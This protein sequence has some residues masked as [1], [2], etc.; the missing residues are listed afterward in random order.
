MGVEEL[1]R[2]IREEVK[3][4]IPATVEITD[5]EFEAAVLVI[6]TKHPER[7]AE[8]EDLVRRLAKK[9]RKRVVVRPDP[10]VLA[11][12][13][14]AD[15]TIRDLVPA[16]AEITE[17]YF[18][19]DIGEVIIEA[20][21]P[22]LVIGRHG[23]TL[24]DIKKAIG[25]APKVIR[26]PPIPSKNVKEIRQFLRT[27]AEERKE[28][29]HRV[30]RRIYRGGVKEDQWVRWTSLGGYREVGRSC[31]LLQTQDTKILIDCGVNFSNDDKA[32]PYLHLSEVW[33]LTQID[34]VILTHAH[35]DHCGLIPLLFKYGYDGPVY[36][37]P[38]TRDLA[39]LLCMD[40]I[41]IAAA[42]GKKPPY[43]SD[44]IRDFVKHS[45]T[46]EYGDTTDIAPDVKLTFSNSGHIL[47]AAV[48]H[49]HIGDGFYNVCCT[50]DMKYER[51]WLFN[52]TNNKFPRLETLIIEATYGGRNDFQ[53]TRQQAQDQM[54]EIC[55]RVL[56]R[57]GKLVVPCFAVGRSQEIMLVMEELIRNGDVP[58][59]PVYL[60]GMI[61]EATAIHTAY[62]EY[63]NN[64]LRNEIFHEGSNPLLSDIF[65]RVDSQEMRRKV[66]DSDEPCVVLA[67][68]GMMSGGPVMEY[69]R[70][71]AQDRR[72]ALVFVGFQAG[73]TLGRRI[74]QGWR[75]I[76]MAA[77]GG[78]SGVVKVELDV[79][80]VDGFSGHSDRRQLMN[81]INNI[82]PKP[83]HVIT[84][85]GE[86]SK[87]IDFATSI[88]KKYH[89]RTEAPMNLET[90]R[91]K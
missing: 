86:E 49:F 27:V 53:P 32:T 18:E 17:L 22:G 57:G 82:T 73:G 70:H 87:C 34:A 84:M 58:R 13:E 26:T 25:W 28:I 65:V 7:F 37:T 80:T 19:P 60:D 16:E 61:W 10:S 38:P 44:H 47:G 72:N 31:H 12:I 43:E 4:E 42:E 29:L 62:P 2:E 14:K 40:Y 3:K 45:V 23:T 78:R 50:S 81:Y 15:K 9:L 88:H 83:D 8:D 68:S 76:P 6:Y 21:K 39:V 24:N 90:I 54:K 5:I 1:L 66:L 91:L 48:S 75:E 85:H 56:P 77:G 71:W 36:L 64:E 11:N 52:P 69:F 79:E 46:L 55:Q 74:Q 41:K 63:L 67:T 89:I 30:G 51:T 35:M 59:V 20:R 33:P